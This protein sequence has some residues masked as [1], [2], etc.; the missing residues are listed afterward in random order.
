M[1]PA[2]SAAAPDWPTVRRLV[3]KVRIS[4]EEWFKWLMNILDGVANK[5]DG[6]TM[7][8]FWRSKRKFR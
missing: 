1:A 7:A 3:A 2:R 5:R 8:P 6:Y 4:A